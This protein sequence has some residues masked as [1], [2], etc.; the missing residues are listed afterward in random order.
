VLVHPLSRPPSPHPSSSLAPS[1]ADTLLGASGVRRAQVR[2][3][4]ADRR[5]R[6]S[7]RLG[8]AHT[9]TWLHRAVVQVASANP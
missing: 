9:G 7:P 1:V 5:R 3:A 8:Q 6:K 2:G 4:G